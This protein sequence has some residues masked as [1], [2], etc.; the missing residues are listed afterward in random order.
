MRERWITFLIAL[1]IFL[2]ALLCLGNVRRGGETASAAA[3]ALESSGKWQGRLFRPLIDALFR[4][5]T[6]Q[7][8]HCYEAW[9]WERTVYLIQNEWDRL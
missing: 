9:R 3:W 4:L 6:R 2:F 5:L 1:D 8:N 7:K